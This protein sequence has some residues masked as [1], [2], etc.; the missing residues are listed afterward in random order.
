M[1]RLREGLQGKARC[2]ACRDRVA[3]PQPWEACLAAE[4]AQLGRA[5]GQDFERPLQLCLHAV[6]RVVRQ[7]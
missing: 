4:H 1:N 6:Q 2:E 3:E 7:E 5:A